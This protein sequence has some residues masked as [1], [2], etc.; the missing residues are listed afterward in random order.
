MPG[1]NGRELAERILKSHPNMKI[2]FTSGYAED[3]IIHQGVVQGNLY[4]IGKPYSMP[5]LARKIRMVME[6]SVPI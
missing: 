4:F 5:D 2:I 6:A 3:L 1:M